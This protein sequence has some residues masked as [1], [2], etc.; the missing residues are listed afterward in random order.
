MLQINTQD[1]TIV[2]NNEGFKSL[3]TFLAKNNYSKIFVVVDAITHQHCLTQLL[4]QLET[5]T[6]IE[7][8]EIESGEENKHIET[9]LGVWNALSEL[10]GDKK[11]IVLNLGG[12]VVTDLGGFVASTF[13]RGIDYINIPTSLLAMVDASVG[14]KNGVDL[15]HLKNQIGVINTPK[16][17]L[18]NTLFLDTL[19][20]IELRSG[21]AE[22]LKHGLIKDKK[23]WQE[24]TELKN[25]TLKD[26]DRLIY[27][28]VLIKKTVVELDPF[29]KKERKTLNFGHTLGHA[30]ESFFLTEQSKTKL[31]HGEAIAIGM[32]LA[33]YISEKQLEFPAEDTEIIKNY[34]IKLYGKI[35]FSNNDIATVIELLKFDKKNEH[36]N[37]NFVLLKAIAEPK[38]DCLVENELIYEAF[39]YY[40]K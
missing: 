39:D 15:G 3:N 38:V 5:E 30:I 33:C 7:V 26:L 12:G 16:M 8:I 9:C 36:G 32:I 35:A 4:Q 27:D 2:F 25:L 18:I 29:E 21:L 31:L 14:G 11:S 22:M 34:L 19:S 28:S 17:V 20:S 1:Y 37:I 24:L 40:S 6:T 13:R 10:D 23:H